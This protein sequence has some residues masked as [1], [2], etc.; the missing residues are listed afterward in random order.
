MCFLERYINIHIDC[1]VSVKT[2]LREIYPLFRII[3]INI[4]F[5]ENSLRVFPFHSVFKRVND[6]IVIIVLLSYFLV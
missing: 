4:E 1:S 2:K 5:I 3:N 6:V